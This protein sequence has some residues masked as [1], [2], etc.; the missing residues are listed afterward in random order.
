M[1]S[2]APPISVTH[3]RTQARA[4]DSPVVIV[5]THCDKLRG[6]EREQ[7]KAE[8]NHRIY[9]KF[10]VGRGPQQ[11]REMGLPKILD[12]IYVGCPSIGRLDGVLE[13]RMA[14]YDIAFALTLAGKGGRVY[15][16]A[17]KL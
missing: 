3:P 5:G 10:L 4:P 9:Q 2:I 8:M 1:H 15:T 17:G 6:E 11:V 14:L 7:R 12:V 16:D 13:L